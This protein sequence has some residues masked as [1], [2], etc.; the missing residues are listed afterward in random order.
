[1]SSPPDGV[2]Q[3]SAPRSHDIA[4]PSVTRLTM[5]SWDDTENFKGKPMPLL[6][7]ADAVE[8]GAIR[9]QLEALEWDCP[10]HSDADFAAEYGYRA[11][12]APATMVGAFSLP[13]YWAPGDAP[14]YEDGLS[15]LPSTS[16]DL[17]PAPGT[18][19]VVTDWRLETHRYLQL[20]D[21]VRSVSTL[22]DVQR[23]ATRLGDG[24]FLTVR[25]E[26]RDQADEP[27]ATRELTIF[28][29]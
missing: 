28:R 6:I 12:I 16:L 25:T 29:F 13:A 11:V 20:G 21:R 22:I 4:A 19:M 3:P 17:I 9:R 24:A 15:K 10:L 18:R 27:V 7:G 14:M 26:F 1:L 23:K 8:A 2:H 5:G